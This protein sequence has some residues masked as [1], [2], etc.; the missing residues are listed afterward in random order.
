MMDIAYKYRLL[1]LFAIAF[2]A[3]QLVFIPILRI[4]KGKNIVDNPDA[5]KLQKEPVPVMGGIAVFFG[6]TVGLCFYKTMIVYT[7]L[8]PVLGAMTVMLYL[9]SI[10]D[11]LSSSPKLRFAIEVIVA[12]VLLYG[13]K[14]CIVNFQ[15]LWG[16]DC[17]PVWLGVLLSVV[18]FVGIVNS[19]NMID[20]VD[21]LCSAFCVLILGCFGVLCFLARDYSFAVLS[22]VCIGSLIP[23]F[24]HNVFG[25]STK[26]F[27]GDGGTM[28]I[29]TAV[30]AMVFVILRRN[31]G[32]QEAFPELNFSRIAFVLSVMSI[33]VSDTIR[34]ML[35]RVF[36][37]KSP[38]SPDKNHLHHIF[39]AAGFSYISITMIELCLDIFVI[40]VFVLS[41]IAGAS[42]SGQVYFVLAATV[43]ADFGTAC[44]LKRLSV[45]N[46]AAYARIRGRAERT[47]V[48]RK[49][50]WLIIQKII[51]G[52]YD[53]L[54][55]RK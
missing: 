18:T 43:L 51:D 17:I 53:S 31:F 46:G 7:S 40:A 28:M 5:R 23:F 10:D 34:V 8:F 37:H 16:I 30:S 26:M 6:I 55:E 29:G 45:R 12:L 44:L 41:W 14:C 21:G 22:A 19:I 9:G 11:I 33:P 3:T 32:I 13:L 50:F 48:E 42:V 47:H 35:V 15:G 36:H 24:L 54:Q 27:I 38:F 2:V 39:V 25:W 4:A 1:I 49:G 20:G 52:R